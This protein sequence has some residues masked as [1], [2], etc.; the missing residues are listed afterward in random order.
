LEEAMRTLVSTV[1]LLS[2]LPASFAR[3]DECEAK[4]AEIGGQTG[5]SANGRAADDSIAL[6][7]WTDEEDSYGAY[8]LC[9]GPLGMSLRYLSPPSPGPKWYEFVGRSGAILTGVRPAAIALEA[10]N[11]V[12][13]ARLRDGVFRSPGSA[14]RITCSMSKTDARADLSLAARR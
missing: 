4:A 14:L 11:C 3:A 1:L 10:R 5:L 8:L 9:R 6:S 13:N 2:I 7:S 12:E